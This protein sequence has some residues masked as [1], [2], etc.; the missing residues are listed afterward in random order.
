[1][2]VQQRS[3]QE[4]L[5][6][7]AR[8]GGSR[9]KAAAEL[10]VNVRHVFKVLRTAKE[11]GL[12]VPSPYVVPPEKLIENTEAAHQAAPEHFHVKGVSSLV[13][14]E[15]NVRQQWIK[16][17]QDVEQRH[18]MLKAAAKALAE[19]IPAQ[20]RISRQKTRVLQ[21]LCS[22]YTITDYHV[23]MLAWR[24]EGG[25]DWDL[26]IAE[27]TLIGCFQ[28]LVDGAPRSKQA[29]I[30]QGGD[31]LHTDGFLPLTPASKHVLDADSRFPKIVKVA[32]RSLRAIINAALAKHEYV[33]IIME[34]GNH[35]PA[36]SVWLTTLFAAL[37]ENEPRVTVEQSPLPYHAFQHGKTMLAF[38]HGHLTK[39]DKL[40]GLMAAQFAKMWGATE[41]RYG[42][43]GHQHHRY[44]KEH[45]GMTV[46]QHRTLAARDAY[47]ARG[48]WHSDRDAKRIDYHTEY[49]EIG[50]GIVTPEMI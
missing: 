16:T 8:N 31:F 38:H 24:E 10:Q 2:P 41:F 40:P 50:Q 22:L 20:A 48:G 28:H 17:D 27:E 49:G 11:Q 33:H 32:V 34:E 19:K 3:M 6:A 5:D 7:V 12:E 43:M 15:G 21:S 37:Y 1:M 35:D 44:V 4:Y 36:S 23:G 39:P 46:E 29:V 30:F 26:K 47:A 25:A 9:V 13:D 14:G 18:A 45:S 42:H